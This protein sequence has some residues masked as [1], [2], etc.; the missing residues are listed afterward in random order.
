MLIKNVKVRKNQVRLQYSYLTEFPYSSIMYT[1]YLEIVTY[2]GLIGN[3]VSNLFQIVRKNA[4]A[5]ITHKYTY[6]VNR[7]IK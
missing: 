3:N 5:H 6:T 1:K 2:L 4:H 7:M